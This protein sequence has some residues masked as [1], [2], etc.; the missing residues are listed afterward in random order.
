MTLAIHGST[1][2][3]VLLLFEVGMVVFVLYRKREPSAALGWSLAVLL[4]PVLG[5]LLFL[6]VGLNE[7]PRRLRRKMAHREEFV[8][9]APGPSEGLAGTPEG[10]PLEP[11]VRIAMAL[12]EPPPRAGNAVELLPDGAEAFERMFAAIEAARHHIHIEMYIFRQDRLG[13]R[14]LD[15]LMRKARAGVEVRLL[16][17]YVGTLARWKLI[18]KLRGAGGKG[19]VFLPLVPFGKRFAPNLRNHRKIVVCDGRIG[20]FGGLN[21]G[22]EYLGRRRKQAW[23]DMHVGVR[24]PAVADLQRIFAEDWDFAEGERLEGPAYFPAPRAE[25]DEVVQILAGGPDRAINPIRQTLLWAITHAERRLW[26][27]SPYLVPDPAIRDA[28]RTAALAGVEVRLLTQGLPPDNWLAYLAGA[29][30]YPDL[31]EAGVRI[32]EFTPGM[33]HAKML[34]SDDRGV[35]IGSANLDY[36]SLHLN[37]ELVGVFT[38]GTTAEGV[39]QRFQGLCAQGTEVTLERLRERGTMHRLG[40]G[41][42]RLLA[43]LL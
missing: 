21:V 36:R 3:L 42:A 28:L 1:W 37:F 8:P 20:F 22:E 16:L 38:R 17:D 19:S 33:M 39:E 6:A 25:G 34:L 18:R 10:H 7:F 15:L 32:F 29:F 5:A 31:I 24:G 27:A 23:C 9:R 26:I 35:A 4:L 43:P 2:A 40:T 13:A 11:A 14:L 12:G 41:I 30:F